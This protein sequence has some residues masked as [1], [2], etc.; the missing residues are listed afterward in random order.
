MALGPGDDRRFYAYVLKHNGTPIWVGLGSGSRHEIRWHC[1]RSAR[2]PPSVSGESKA[3]TL[4]NLLHDSLDSIVD[5]ISGTVSLGRFDSMTDKMIKKR[6][7]LKAA[8]KTKQ[9]KAG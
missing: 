3:A 6:A 7:A 8:A 9:A 5:T 1:T 4:F 2:L